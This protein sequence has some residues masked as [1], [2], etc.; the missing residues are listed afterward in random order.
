MPEGKS[1]K[2]S[3]LINVGRITTVFGV[4]GWLKIH[5][6][7]QPM[8]N[9]CH[10]SPWWLKTRHGVKQ[11]EI[12]DFKPH[13]QN[14][15]VH[16]KGVDDRDEAKEWCQVDIAVERDQIPDL[17]TGDFYWFQLQGL[18]VVS[19]YDG[20]EVILGKV[21]HLLETGAN[22]VLVVKGDIDSLD[23]VERLIPYVPEQYIKDV[24]LDNQ[25]IK[26][27]WDPEF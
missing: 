12:D 19:I 24:D 26:V 22:D 13:G 20:Q 27:D 10:Y 7:T 11:V 25:T 14:M 3:N 18:K 2:R 23:E 6:A 1:Q 9:I 17:E 16:I 21:S 15:V 4:K 5:S 8:D